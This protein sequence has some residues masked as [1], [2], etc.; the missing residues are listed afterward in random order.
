MKLQAHL[1]H[2]RFSAAADF[3]FAFETHFRSNKVT[4]F[5]R[6]VEIARI[7][8]R[9]GASN[10]ILTARHRSKNG[11][12][13]R[14]GKKLKWHSTLTCLVAGPYTAC[15]GAKNSLHSAN[16]QVSNLRKRYFLTTFVRKYTSLEPHFEVVLPLNS[17]CSSWTQNLEL[18][19][20]S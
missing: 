5:N 13:K 12:R 1:I 20:T 19:S 3:P 18:A 16:T 10:L 17:F 15:T 14:S 4:N 11:Q 9:T 8:H 2:T 6:A 7:L